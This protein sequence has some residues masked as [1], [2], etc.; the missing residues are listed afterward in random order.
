MGSLVMI[1]GYGLFGYDYG[2]YWLSL[3]KLIMIIGYLVMILVIVV[4]YYIGYN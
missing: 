4:G 2:Y 1:V 3:L